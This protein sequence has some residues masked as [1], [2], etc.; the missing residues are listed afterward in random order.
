MPELRLQ[1]PQSVIDSINAKLRNINGPD[2]RTL[3][4]NDIGRDALAVYKWAVDQTDNGLAV[5]AADSTRSPV[6]QIATENLPARAPS[7]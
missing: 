5:V 7:R 2:A 6:V 4:V 1:V 3:S